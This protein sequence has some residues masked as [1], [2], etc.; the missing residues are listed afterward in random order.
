MT[1]HLTSRV[2]PTLM[3]ALLCVLSGCDRRQQAADPPATETSTPPEGSA[4]ADNGR[5]ET[6]GLVG[7]D[8]EVEPIEVTD[9]GPPAPTVIFTAGIKGYTEPCGCTLD[10]LLG[11]ID[12]VVGS[13]QAMRALAP[14]SLVLDA[15]NLLYEHATLDDASRAQELRKTEVILDAAKAMGMAATTP[16][17]T[18]LANGLDDYLAR[19]TAADIPILTT[20]LTRA[21]G[22]AFGA[23]WIVREVGAERIGVFAVANPSLFE[24]VEGVAVSDAG[25]A[26]VDAVNA[27]NNEGATTIIALLQG[28]IT[29]ARTLFAN[30]S[31][32][33]FIIVGAEPRETDEVETVGE[34]FT[35][36]A[37]DQGRNVGRLK[38]HCEQEPGGPWSSAR[39][40]STEEVE[41]IDRV[42]ATLESQLEG[43]A[44]APDG[45]VPPFVARQQE[46][47][48]SLQAERAAMD[49]DALDFSGDGCRFLYRPIPM[50][51]GYPT[52]DAITASMRRYNQALQAINLADAHPPVPAAPGTASYVGD[53]V[54]S[55]CHVAEAAHFATTAHARAWETLVSRDKQFDRSCVGCHVTGYEQPGG[56]TLGHTEGLENV[57]C[58]QCHG[59]G[60]LH[61][62]DPTSAMQLGNTEQTC[63]GCHNEE[64]SPRFQF[65][66]YLPRILGEGHG[67]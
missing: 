3:L 9:E 2:A 13:I 1:V 11:G 34:A 28:D 36:E 21:D 5:M 59:P 19:V 67:R 4:A 20:N 35:L 6:A 39:T 58:E 29:A 30:T 25:P 46:R 37:Y 65:E 64:H 22:T 38:L 51:P 27:L 8:V 24:D 63:T 7:T 26:I 62:A 17:I 55:G 14:A 52:N 61:V 31:G 57:Q 43:V 48:A 10:L 45:S 15:G 60:S 41:R 12:R 23:P 47:L 44:P 66:S 54:C 49:D 42:I 18:D 53:A 32:V 33:D 40:A 56:S 50:V 16:G